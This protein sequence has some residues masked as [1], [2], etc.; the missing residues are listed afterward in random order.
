MDLAP[1]ATV[2]S[3]LWYRVSGLVPRLRAS[4]RV[5]VRQDVGGPSRLLT[6]TLTG[7]HHLVDADGWAFVGRLDGQATVDEIWAQLRRHQTRPPT[8]Q[9]VLDWLAALDRSGLLQGARL[10]DLDGVLSHQE[11]D[12][13]RRRRE[14]A[15]PLSWRVT[16]TDTA[17]RIARLDPL[18]RALFS[19][20][21]ALAWLAVVAVGAAVAVSQATELGA[22]L[23][24]RAADP[25]FLAAAA[26]AWLPLKVLHELGHA[27]AL[28]R[29]GGRVGAYGVAFLWGLP[30]P[31]VDASAASAFGSRRERLV[32]TGAGIA[33]EVAVAALAVV[34]WWAAG[35]HGPA[36]DAALALV[37]AGGVSTLLANAN[38]LVRMD[39][40]HLLVDAAGL[41]NLASR[42]RR[43][44]LDRLRARLL[45]LPVPVRPPA[46]RAERLA[47]PLYAPSAWAFGVAVAVS[48]T[49]WIASHAPTVA[50]AAAVLGTWALALR[51]LWALAKWSAAAPELDG[52]RLRLSVIAL[53]AGAL[54]VTAVLAVPLP[55]T[56]VAHGVAWMPEEAIVRSP[57]DGFVVD[58]RAEGDRPVTLGQPLLRVEN[59]DLPLRHARLR[60]DR[61]AAEMAAGAARLVDP[62]R[63]ARADADVQRLL[64]EEADVAHRLA[65]RDV[66]SSRAGRLA[67][68][69]P[70][71]LAGRPVRRGEI[72]GHVLADDELV[73]RV[74]LPS[75]AA[76]AL[77]RGVARV[78]VL[79]VASPHAGHAGRWDGS[80]P[81]AVTRLPTAALG[82][83]AGGPVE[84]D[85][86]DADGLRTRE[87]V[88][89]LDVPVPGVPA[90]RL[91]S[92]LLVRFEHDASPLGPRLAMRL[93]QGL[94][95]HLGE[96]A[97]P[98]AGGGTP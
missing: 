26:L 83:A 43:W 54:A 84:T 79:D 32:V 61:V 20:A 70:R 93:R 66:A 8:Q 41:P 44:W 68:A 90:R 15:H 82:V 3:P 98:S 23:A 37:V 64:A 73:A 12:R 36:A 69:D 27:L 42:S 19:P 50:V 80:V 62:A 91:G 18:G 57:L 89:V 1:S 76:E 11:E 49:V 35:G 47:L 55:H 81:A 13:R 30:A 67:W 17:H 22:A 4:V 77:A 71:R 59:D 58:V 16:W 65:L 25:R 94:L 39:G 63:A 21:G 48:I 56:T 5:R 14:R 60:A 78:E 51:P 38:P 45:R 34:A 7:R 92:R 53:V 95:R 10:P 6:D 88:V 75:A 2:D 40:Y 9:E 24:T 96:A 29:H 86:T 31:F 52:R 72:L 74:A 46:S 97:V 85:P 33:V 28:R 87:P